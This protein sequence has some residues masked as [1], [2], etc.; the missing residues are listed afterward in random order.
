MKKILKH[1][2]VLFICT[3][4]YSVDE[5]LILSQEFPDKL[6]DFRFFKD[7]SAQ[8]P[9]DKVIPYELISTLFSDYSYKQR[10]V[11]V[12]NQ[13]KAEYQEDWVFDFPTGSA[14]IK[15]FYYPIDERNPELG[16]NLLET[17][18]LLKKD[19][20]W[21]AVS[22]AWNKEQNEAFKKIAGK[23]I[24]VSWT[25]FMGEEKDV[26]YRVPNVNQCK[27]C[28]DADDKISPIGPKARNINKD[29]AFKEGTFNQLTYWMNRQIIDEY[30]LDLVSPVDW[31][32]ESKDINDRVRSYLDV[33]CGHCHSPT[34][35]ANSTGLYLH[36]NETRNIN[37]GVFKKPVATGRGSGGLKY[38]IVPGEPEESILLHRMISMDP[39]VMMPE[40]G[41]ALTHTEAVEMVRDWILLMED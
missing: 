20:G 35:N 3:Y 25:D 27:E 40:S 15:T 10:W 32:D 8:V 17:R 37:L 4:I 34:G 14:L 38:S 41:R 33:N 12:P 16:K 29:F 21:E 28:H 26:R 6:S 9:H 18:L 24:N 5:E 7:A 30:P 31:T 36:L 23:T 2:F 13:K 39:G 22:Y 11:Y 19:K 1:F